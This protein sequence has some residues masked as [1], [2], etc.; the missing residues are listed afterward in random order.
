MLQVVKQKV[1]NERE[2]EIPLTYVERKSRN[3]NTQVDSAYKS[4]VEG[5]NVRGW[6][7]RVP[8]ACLMGSV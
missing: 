7:R 6:S 4:C 8:S 5:K 3:L 1:G 2:L